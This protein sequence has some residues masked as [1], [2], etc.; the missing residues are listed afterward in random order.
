MGTTGD[1]PG[2]EVYDFL[3]NYRIRVLLWRH[4]QRFGGN[5]ET[6]SSFYAINRRL[7][8]GAKRDP[9]YDRPLRYANRRALVIIDIIRARRIGTIWNEGD[10]P[11]N[12][13]G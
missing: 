5:Q 4:Q 3:Y 8:I 13:E 12:Y 11:V 1:R 2:V 9:D 6:L 7:C 10:Q